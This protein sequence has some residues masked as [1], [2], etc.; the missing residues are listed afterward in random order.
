MEGVLTGKNTD[1]EYDNDGE[2]QP[3]CNAQ[4]SALAPTHPQHLPIHLHRGIH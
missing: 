1:G 2:E 3:A 4:A